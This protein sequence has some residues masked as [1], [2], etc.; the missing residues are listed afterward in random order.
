MAKRYANSSRLLQPQVEQL[1]DVLLLRLP[2]GQDYTSVLSEAHEQMS[3]LA[4]SMT[5]ALQGDGPEDASCTNLVADVAH[6]QS[7]VDDY[8][9][10]PQVVEPTTK[11]ETN[12]TAEPQDQAVCESNP[13]ENRSGPASESTFFRDLTLLVGYCRSKRQPVSLILFAAEGESTIN[14]TLATIV[15]RLLNAACRIDDVSGA[16]SKSHS[17]YG[18][19]LV[20]P[21]FDRQEAVG[22]AQ[23]AIEQIEA[24]VEQLELRGTSLACLWGAGVALVNLPPQELSAARSARDRSKVSRCCAGR[25]SLGSQESGDLLVRS[26]SKCRVIGASVAILARRSKQANLHDSSMQ[27]NAARSGRNPPGR[28]KCA[29]TALNRNLH[30]LFTSVP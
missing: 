11:Q 17:T 24:S 18:R 26:S 19:V 2:A 3:L 22:V 27:T 25:R 20:L 16:I 28:Y 30:Q 23:R 29:M 13:Q 14:E 12:E 8:L 7:A 9:Q 4:E 15:V 1:A 5:G 6:L 21:G 10:R